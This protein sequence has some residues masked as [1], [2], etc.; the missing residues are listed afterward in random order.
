MHD[1]SIG[2]DDAA[3]AIAWPEVADATSLSDKDRSSRDWQT[4]RP[5]SERTTSKSSIELTLRSVNSG[6]VLE[7]GD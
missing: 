2:W 3:L 5:F 4:C 7:K 1:R 6:P